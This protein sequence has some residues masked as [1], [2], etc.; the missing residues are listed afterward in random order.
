MSQPEQQNSN[1]PT[2]PTSWM[3]ADVGKYA[4]PGLGFLATGVV[5]LALGYGVVTGLM[6]SPEKPVKTEVQAK[7]LEEKTH[8]LIAQNDDK[9]GF[10]FD[11]GLV[12]KTLE[13]YEAEVKSDVQKQYEDVR[14]KIQK[15][16]D[17]EKSRIVDKDSKM[18][19]N[20]FSGAN[21]A[22][23]FEEKP[24]PAEKPAGEQVETNLYKGIEEIRK[25]TYNGDN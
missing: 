14:S 10:V 6:Y 13:Q 16:Y 9:T 12:G 19:E 5:G 3:E 1:Q 24:E 11:D 8:V 7:S 25:G 15:N 17:N 21:K 22:W 2:Q 4:L 20:A 23:G 18:T